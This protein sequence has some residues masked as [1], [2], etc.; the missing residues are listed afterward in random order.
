[1]EVIPKAFVVGLFVPVVPGQSPANAERLNRIW[2][3]VG[4][5]HGYTQLQLAPDQA[6]GNFLGASPEIGVTIQPPLLQVRDLLGMPGRP[7]V[8]DDAAE[9]AEEILRTVARHLGQDQFFNL[10]IKIVYHAPHPANDAKG[11][12]LNQLLSRG[13]EGLDELTLGGDF[14]GGVKF[15]AGHPQGE[16]TLLL[17]PARVDELKSL[18]IDLDAQ[19]PGPAT[20]DS[21]A[22]RA[23]DAHAYVSQNVS[24]FLDRLV[25]GGAS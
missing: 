2:S 23:R 3:D 9:R 19:Y 14:W 12:I 22:D 18:F 15:V 16:Y 11:F 17:E 25:E 7:M 8:P 24:R 4:P 20:L 1:M 13:G 10:G 6:A 5:S 21:I